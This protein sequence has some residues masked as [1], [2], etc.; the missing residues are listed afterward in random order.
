MHAFLLCIGET[1]VF[2]ASF[3]VKTAMRPTNDPNL[4]RETP[5]AAPQTIHQGTKTQCEH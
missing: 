2:T 3:V 4:N 1:R 5:A